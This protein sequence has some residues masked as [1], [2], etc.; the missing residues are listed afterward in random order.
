MTLNRLSVLK[1]R[2]AVVLAPGPL[3]TRTGSLRWNVW[4]Q[5]L[6]TMGGCEME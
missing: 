2:K 1:P 5:V 3:P 4:G 6:V